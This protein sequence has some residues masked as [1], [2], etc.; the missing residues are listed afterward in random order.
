MRSP[1]SRL[2]EPQ[3]RRELPWEPPKAR[4]R[5]SRAVAARR[6]TAARSPV[7]DNPSTKSRRPSTGCGGWNS[8]SSEVQPSS[9]GPWARADCGTVATA[10]ARATAAR[11]AAQVFGRFL[12]RALRLPAP[13]PLMFSFSLSSRRRRLPNQPWGRKGLRPPL[14]SRLLRL[15]EGRAGSFPHGAPSSAGGR[16][17]SAPAARARAARCGPTGT[18]AQRGASPPAGTSKGRRPPGA[19]ADRL[20]SPRR[21]RS[22][23]GPGGRPKPSSPRTARRGRSGMR[24]R[25]GRTPPSSPRSGGR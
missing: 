15:G 10:A 12:R 13:L 25:T 16:G 5:M 17:R 20:S 3:K 18:A 7:T 24:R 22:P 9:P 11:A 8:I 23:P 4:T 21:R 1:S 6:V 14:R 2:A 19:A